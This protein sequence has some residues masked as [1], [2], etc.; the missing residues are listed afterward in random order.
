MDTMTAQVDLDENAT[1]LVKKNTRGITPEEARVWFEKMYSTELFCLPDNQLFLTDE[2]SFNL[3]YSGACWMFERV[4][5]GK[6]Q[7]LVRD[8]KSMGSIRVMHDHVADVIEKE[9]SLPQ[10]TVP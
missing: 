7:L 2:G 4:F 10:K 9:L 8:E 1:R 3:R 6:S 5:D